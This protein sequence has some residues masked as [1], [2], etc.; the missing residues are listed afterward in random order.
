MRGYLCRFRCWKDNQ[1]SFLRLLLC[2]QHN[3]SGG[4]RP[5]KIRNI[6]LGVLGLVMLVGTVVPANAAGYR[7]HRHHHHHKH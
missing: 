2:M 5:M 7:H 4:N 3:V 6:L 1:T